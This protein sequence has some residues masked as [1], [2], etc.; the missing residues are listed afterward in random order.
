MSKSD[1]LSRKCSSCGGVIDSLGKSLPFPQSDGFTSPTLA[2]DALVIDESSAQTRILLIRRGHDPD[3]GKL[4]LPGGF[5]DYGEDPLDAVLRE[6]MEECGIEGRNPTPVV[7]RGAPGRD[8]R[9]HIVSIIH[10]V[11]VGKNQIP[12]PGDDA[13][14]AA[15][16]NLDD[17]LSFEDSEWA[18]DHKSI[19]IEALELD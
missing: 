15:W 10:R 4:A 7:V 18:F 2:A 12:N 19:I 3:Q 1:D 17:V 16:W 6:L 11:E 9:K 8:T 14:E 5:V 13:A